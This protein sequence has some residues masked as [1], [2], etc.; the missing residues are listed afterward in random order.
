MTGE[1]KRARF[2]IKKALEGNRVCLVSGGDPGIYGMAG[3]VLE[4][5]SND[6]REKI[7][8]EVIP[9]ISAA[10]ACASLLGAP[11]VH[12]FAV[13]SLSDCLTEKRLIEERVKK[14]C[15]GDFV[16]VFYNPR[17]KSRVTPLKA[18]WQILMKYKSPQTPVGI[19]R[20][21][22]RENESIEITELKNML[23]LRMIDMRTTIIVGNSE[24]YVKGGYMITPRGYNII[25]GNDR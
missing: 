3:I 12:D 16:I 5:L 22:Y 24:T 10:S 7:K 1:V 2:A 23:C 18:A 15:Q 6:E 20:N 8:I 13:I 14:V 25:K 21:A 17:S 19:V 4:L 9:G 11:L